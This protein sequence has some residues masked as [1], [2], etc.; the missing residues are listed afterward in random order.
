[1][2][3]CLRQHGHAAVAAAPTGPH[4]VCLSWHGALGMS[5]SQGSK[6]S[7]VCWSPVSE[8]TQTAMYC[9]EHKGLKMFPLKNK[10]KKKKIELF[11]SEMSTCM[12]TGQKRLTHHFIPCLQTLQKPVKQEE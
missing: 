1:M 6:Q 3:L 12:Q 7:T 10:N 5:W 2:L 11:R 9:Q 8:Q 4:F